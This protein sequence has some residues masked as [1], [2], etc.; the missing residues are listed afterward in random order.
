MANTALVRGQMSIALEIVTIKLIIIQQI[1][2]GFY[3][4]GFVRTRNVASGVVCL[5]SNPD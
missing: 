1:H 5:K 4:L 2:S 3:Y